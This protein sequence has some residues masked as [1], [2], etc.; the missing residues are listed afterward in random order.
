MS[1]Y[2]CLVRFTAGALTVLTACAPLVEMPTPSPDGPRI[3]NLAFDPPVSIVGG[4]V[5]M[6]FQF[7]TN[8]SEITGG[9][10][11]WS[12][13]LGKR[14]TIDGST[15]DHEMFQGKASGEVTVPLRLKKIGHY[16]YRVQVE[17]RAGRQSNVLEQDLTVEVSGRG[18]SPHAPARWS[19]HGGEDSR[20]GDLNMKSRIQLDIPLQWL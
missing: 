19:G 20:Q 14:L 8:G 4:T 17:D 11:R 6:R 2:F 7:E 5:T 9:L 3:S 16:R 13:T 1:R 10:V 15:L 18:G 12:V